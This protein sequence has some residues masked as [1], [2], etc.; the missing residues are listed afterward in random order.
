MTYLYGGDRK[1]IKEH[2]VGI[3][4][5]AIPHQIVKHSLLCRYYV[6]TLP[7]S[8]FL[9]CPLPGGFVDGVLHGQFIVTENKG[10]N[11]LDQLL[12][13]SWSVDIKD[14]ESSLIEAV[15]LEI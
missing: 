6:V 1:N 2:E 12:F 10:S 9:Q 8:W 3:F 11:Q 4:W 7:L 5:A 13:N 15:L 14:A